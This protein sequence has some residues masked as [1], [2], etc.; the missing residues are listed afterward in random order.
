[1][2]KLRQKSDAKLTFVTL[3][4]LINGE[5]EVTIDPSGLTLGSEYILTL[6]S[7][8]PLNK[9]QTS[10]KTEQI[11]LVVVNDPNASYIS[12]K[13]PHDWVLEIDRDSIK[14]VKIEPQRELKT[15]ISYE[16]LTSTIHY[17]NGNQ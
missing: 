9:I 16:D 5:Y 3:S 8:E 13:E 6:E 12:A 1:M 4:E 2:A 10:L 7:Y 11:K 14:Q 17:F 15:F